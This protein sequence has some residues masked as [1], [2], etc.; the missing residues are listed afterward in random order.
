MGSIVNGTIA[1][2]PFVNHKNHASGAAYVPLPV[3][4]NVASIYGRRAKASRPAIQA[5]N[6]KGE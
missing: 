1:G 2:H 5:I 4:Q 6:P 3:K